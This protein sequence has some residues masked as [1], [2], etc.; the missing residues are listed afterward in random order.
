MFQSPPL[1]LEFRVARW[2]VERSPSEVELALTTFDE[3][4][5]SLL[6]E[7]RSAAVEAS[8]A[9]RRLEQ[10]IPPRT[11]AQIERLGFR[12]SEHGHFP[13]ASL[14]IVAT[15]MRGQFVGRAEL[16]S[17]IV[18]SA[19][20]TGDL[21][22][23]DKAFFGVVCDGPLHLP[24]DPTFN[25]MLQ[26]HFDEARWER[27]DITWDSHPVTRELKPGYVFA[28]R[29]TLVKPLGAGGMGAVWLATD[30]SLRGDHV[31]LKFLPEEM[32]HNPGAID[33]LR[34]EVLNARKL[35]HE[36]IVRIYDL[37]EHEGTA[38]ISMEYIDGLTL[39][40]HR[41]ALP[42]KVFEVDDLLPLLPGLGNAIDYAHQRRII[43]QDLKPMNLMLT[44]SGVLKVMDFGLAGTLSETRTRLSRIN[45]GTA[46]TT[47]Y[48]SP[49]Q[50]E[51]SVPSIANDI[52]SLGVTLY[53]LLTRKPPFYGEPLQPQILGG[54]VQSIAERRAVFGVEGK[55]VPAAWEEAI[56]QALSKVAAQRPKSA[57]ELCA[58][59]VEGAIKKAV[60]GFS[61]PSEGADKAAPEA[62]LPLSAQPMRSESGQTQTAQHVERDG[63][64]KSDETI[65]RLSVSDSREASWSA[66]GSDSASPALPTAS[67]QSRKVLASTPSATA[68]YYERAE[69][70]PPCISAA[71]LQDTPRKP[72]AR[73]IGIALLV[74]GIAAYAWHTSVAAKRIVA[75]DSIAEAKVDDMVKT[76]PSFK[77]L[78]TDGNSLGMKFIPFADSPEGIVLGCEHE[79]RT[80]DYADFIAS[81]DYKMEDSGGGYWERSNADDWKSSIDE[82]TRLPVGRGKEGTEAEI[83]TS[84]HPVCSVSYIDAQAF[85]AWLTKRERG[86]DLIGQKDVYRLPTDAEW[87]LMVGLGEETGSTP[88]E[89]SLNGPKNIYPWGSTYPPTSKDGNYDGDQDGF[90]TTAPVKSFSPNKLGFYDLGGNVWEWCDDWCDGDGGDMKLRVLRGGS[91]FGFSNILLSSSRVNLWPGYRGKSEGFRCVLVVYSR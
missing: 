63:L 50:F 91:W 71:A 42:N 62:L 10:F 80:K 48:M 6:I 67:L 49:Q 30:S 82:S 16:R 36:H 53:E 55:L 43:H 40:A 3:P 31:A 84:T 65:D 73:M 46:G 86:L 14:R 35:A 90:A 19:K 39:D 18:V 1:H 70:M 56:L 58:R 38:A 57:S 9:E 47:A 44:K 75:L 60:Q 23:G 89:K 27:L 83:K 85:C 25:Q 22:I 13:N 12:P 41:R 74:L 28:K 5:T 4:I 79:T 17:T 66:G 8:V 87:S 33:D 51:T 61:P 64:E 52:Y 21:R 69:S 34:D 88:R 54:E 78:I 11:A 15:T 59:L 29:F 37:I 7:L 24:V 76:L 45:R 77:R 81:G 20:P 32:C 26:H 68:S 2:L 72:L